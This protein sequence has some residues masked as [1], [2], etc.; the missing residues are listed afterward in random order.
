M[1]RG[2]FS[3]MLY[4]CYY[5]FANKLLIK[6]MNFCREVT[7]LIFSHNR[8]KKDAFITACHGWMFGAVSWMKGPGCYS[9]THFN[10]RPEYYTVPCCNRTY[11]QL[12][13]EPTFIT[14]DAVHDF[15]DVVEVV[16]ERLLELC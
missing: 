15:G 8:L 4:G 3:K 2:P 10:Q 6:H 9:T 5:T 16:S 14:V 7:G 13:P 1:L 11:L 12:S